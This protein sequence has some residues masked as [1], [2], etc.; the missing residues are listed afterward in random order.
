MEDQTFI[1]AGTCCLFPSR[2]PSLTCSF[3]FRPWYTYSTRKLMMCNSSVTASGPCRVTVIRASFAESL[4]SAHA[5]VTC[6]PYLVIAL[7]CTYRALLHQRLRI[8]E[9]QCQGGDPEAEAWTRPSSC[10]SRLDANP[11]NPSYQEAEVP[12]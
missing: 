2:F 6:Q 1:T 3:I 9:T 11:V 10:S 8:Q 12:N 7:S 4:A 5:L